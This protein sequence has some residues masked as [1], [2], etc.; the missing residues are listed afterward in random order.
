M[1]WLGFLAWLLLIPAV[2]LTAFLCVAQNGALYG[3]LQDRTGVTE[4][5]TGVSDE[6]RYRLNGALAAYICGEQ[7]ELDDRAA[8]FGADQIAFNETERLHM[9]DVRE[10]FALARRVCI[11]V[12]I[13]GGCLLA[14]AV[15]R[16][17]RLLPGYFAAAGA[18]AAAALAVIIWAASDFTRAFVWFHKM[19]F[20]NEL[21]LLNPATDLMIRMLPEAFFA[22]IAM[23]SAIAMAAA[24]ALAGAA[25]W[26]RDW[27]SK[28]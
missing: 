21:W 22:G 9:A 17:K 5:V 26:A 11:A 10:L 24:V 25:A 20:T 18:W 2:M 4:A 8:V 3:A 16:G 19:L 27:F 6:D 13:G 14:F 7:A 1:R 23:I 12:W 28:R 15:V